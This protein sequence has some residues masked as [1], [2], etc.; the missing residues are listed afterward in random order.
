MGK[1]GRK[2]RE[3]EPHFGHFIFGVP[4]KHSSEK[5]IVQWKK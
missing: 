4:M 2:W 1:T 3:A 5:S